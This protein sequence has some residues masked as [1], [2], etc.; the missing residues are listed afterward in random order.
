M[1]IGR[2]LHKKNRAVSNKTRSPPSSFSF[3]GQATKHTTVKWSIIHFQSE[4]WERKLFCRQNPCAKQIKAGH[5]F[6][7]QAMIGCLFPSHGACYIK[8]LELRSQWLAA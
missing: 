8:E 1:L 6:L 5:F 4:K 2:D 7:F 3:K